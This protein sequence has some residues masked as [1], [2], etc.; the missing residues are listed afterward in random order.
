L[1]IKQKS[2]EWPGKQ[3][4]SHWSDLIGNDLWVCRW[5]LFSAYL[6]SL[7]AAGAI[8]LLPWPLKL[9]IDYVLAGDP[10]PASLG[11]IQQFLSTEFNIDS[12][13]ANLTILFACA[14]ALIALAAALLSAAD[15][16]ISARI[17]EQLVLRIRLRVLARLQGLPLLMRSN[18]SKGD[19]VF[20]ISGDVYQF[21]R[22]L[23]KT[24]PTIFRHLVVSLFT[25]GVMFWIE[26]WL[27]LAG[28]TIVSIMAAIVV[29]YG[30]RLHGAS[31]KKRAHEGAVAGFSQEIVKAL[32]TIQALGLEIYTQKRFRGINEQSLAAGVNQ[33]QVAVGMERAMQV[34][35]GIA[36]A[37]IMGACALYVVRDQLTIGD[38]TVFIAYMI[39]L[40]K[41]VEKINELALAVSRGISRGE[42]LA[43]LFAEIPQVDNSANLK[44]ISHCQ[45][46]IQFRSV[47]FAYPE[48]DPS[49]VLLRDISFKLEKG[50]LAVVTGPSG[51]GKSTLISLLLRQLDPLSGGIYLDNRPYPE[52]ALRSLRNQFAVML[53]LHDLFAGTI[54]ELLWMHELPP[55]D[56]LIW[57]A[58]A[59]VDLKQHFQQLP[60]GL[61]AD[62]AEDGVN[63]SGGQRARLS[64]AR[65]L[66]LD[67]PILLLDEPLANIDSQ[68]QS[69]I[70]NAL[71]RIKADKTCL[72]ISHQPILTE[73]A[74]K[75]FTLES[76]QLI[77]PEDTQ[78]HA[79]EEGLA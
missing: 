31:R 45:G 78:L 44:T 23:T 20:R 41:P 37:L 16:V 28:L 46:T 7:L 10:L 75:V 18:Y 53:Q 14:Y 9:T 51:S 50:Q 34:I 66:L 43:A 2:A 19:L 60:G 55:D 5:Q 15:K 30:A 63:L 12:S 13:A 26:P 22:L 24:I 76:G 67:R 77:Q 36:V 61:A 71:D 42:R 21:V 72:V 29:Y 40:L 47:N 38:M 69:I 33:V 58:L 74:D 3:A 79:L 65:T 56:T 4:I 73:R 49:Q 25:L 17:R 48:Q 35:N 52:L 59:L 68:S 32:P 6:L 27:A 64:L 11:V 70:L 39:Q 62:M 57:K 1:N 54:R 8:I